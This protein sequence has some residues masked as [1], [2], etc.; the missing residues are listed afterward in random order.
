MSAYRFLCPQ[1]GKGFEEGASLTVCPDCQTLLRFTV[2]PTGSASSGE[3]LNLPPHLD[4]ASLMRQVLAE[5]PREEAVDETLRGVLQRECA[6][7]DENLFPLFSQM[8]SALQRMWGLSRLDAVRRVADARSEMH[9]SPQGRPEI[10]SVH[11]QAAGLEQ[12]PTE[13][14]EQVLAQLEEAARTGALIP[15]QFVLKPPTQTAGRATALLVV[16]GAIAVALSFWLWQLLA[17]R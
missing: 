9:V 3:S 5:E 11:F 15:R 17:A 16:A 2:G 1:C 14:R 4:V 7:A 13:Q 6:Q 8:L 12:L 10:S